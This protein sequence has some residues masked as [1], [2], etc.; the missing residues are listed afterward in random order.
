MSGLGK[1]IT[2]GS[3]GAVLAVGA[4]SATPA[5]AYIACSRWHDC[6]RAPV[7]VAYPAHVGV[8]WHPDTWAGYRAPSY[9]YWATV[10]AGRGY[11]YRGHWR[12]W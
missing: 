7:R 2:I 4:L 8:A 6:W 9:H 11:Y 12:R 5:S 3:L 1:L 10:P